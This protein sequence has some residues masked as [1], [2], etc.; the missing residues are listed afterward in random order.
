M[1]YY[2]DSQNIALLY[3]EWLGRMNI[4]ILLVEKTFLCFLSWL[5]TTCHLFQTKI[6]NPDRKAF[7]GKSKVLILLV[8]V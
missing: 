5:S 4:T 1:G 8:F 2:V 6:L 7:I 3:S